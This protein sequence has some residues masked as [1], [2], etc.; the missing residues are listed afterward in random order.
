MHFL[1]TDFT[2]FIDDNGG[3][4]SGGVPKEGDGFMVD[5]NWASDFTLGGQHF[6]FE[7]HAEYISRRSQATGGHAPYWILAQPQFRYDAGSLLG[8]GLDRFYVGIEWQ[9]WI[10]KLGD[11]GTDENVPQALAVW[12]F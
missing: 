1:N 9:V 7:G 6:R 8:G 3:V 2:A 11:G 4:A 10:N 5:V 12:H